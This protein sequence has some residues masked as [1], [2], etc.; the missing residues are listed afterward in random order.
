MNAIEHVI[1]PKIERTLAYIV[2]ELDELERE[3]FFRL[4][5]VTV[6]PSWK[7][8]LNSYLPL[9]IA[10]LLRFKTRRRRFVK[11]RKRQLL[12]EKPKVC[13]KSEIF[14]SVESRIITLSF[15]RSGYP[16]WWR[17]IRGGA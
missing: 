2:S 7:S 14:C 17:H 12:R 8:K 9:F 15:H 13:Q 6:V 1:I 16:G 10:F 5:K 11:Q 3:E 4:K